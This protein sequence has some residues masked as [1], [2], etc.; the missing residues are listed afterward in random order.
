MDRF[1]TSAQSLSGVAIS[2][3]T[4]RRQTL[5]L[6]LA[7]LLV[8]DTE[9]KILYWNRAAEVMYG[10]KCDDAI[11]RVGHDLMRTQFPEPWDQMLAK[12]RSGRQW[13]GELRHTRSNGAE[14]VV[15]SQW[16]AQFDDSGALESIIEVNI[17]VTARKRLEAERARFAAIVASSDD[18]IIGKT[19]DGMVTSWNAGAQ[20]L[21]GYTAAEMAGQ[22]MSRIIPA[23]RQVEETAILARLRRGERIEHYETV[24]VTKDGRSVDVSL[25]VSPV[26]DETGAITGASK[27][28]RDISER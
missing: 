10:F 21:F 16:I 2:E 13:Q 7:P 23:D 18:A 15:S 19:L 9:D 28:A 27:I 17:D 20:R 22:P 5:M 26:R 14:M 3:E 11:G 24:R 4:L 6:E 8:R 25:T 12:L 1:R